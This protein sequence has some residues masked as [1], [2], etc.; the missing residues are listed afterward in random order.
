VNE[1][2]IEVTADELTVDMHP[3]LQVLLVLCFTGYVACI[4]AAMGS[5]Y[6]FQES[7]QMLKAS[8]LLAAAA[9]GLSFGMLQGGYVVPQ[10]V[11]QTKK[12]TLKESRQKQGDST[13][14]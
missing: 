12:Q 6:H 4:F 11:R 14:E 2:S 9:G 1:E 10:L 8:L 3:L 13:G 7:G 5:A